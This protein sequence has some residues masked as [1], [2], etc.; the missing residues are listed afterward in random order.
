[1]SEPRHFPVPIDKSWKILCDD[2]SLA[3]Y[4]NGLKIHAFVLMPNHFHL[5]A[6]VTDVPLGKVLCQFLSSASRTMNFESGKINQRWGG[7][8]FKCEVA[9]YH[10]YMNAYKYIYQ[11]PLR[12]K[13]C[14]RVEEWPYSTLNG[15]LGQTPLSIPLE[16][17]HLL[18][19]EG[20][21]S[22]ETNHLDW[23]NQQIQPQALKDMK[24]A[25][26]KRSFKLPKK[27]NKANPLE[28]RLI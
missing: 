25:L 14:S 20:C 21:L 8:V 15:L 23:L 5:L 7:R 19:P 10:Y 26:Q 12:A 13:L 18:S 4:K 6:T 22:F 17:D 27:K 9:S 1:M 11:N 2:L 16:P 28:I 3:H 24:K